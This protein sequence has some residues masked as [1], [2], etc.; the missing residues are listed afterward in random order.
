MKKQFGVSLLLMVGYSHLGGMEQVRQSAHGN[1][2]LVYELHSI[3]VESN[4]SEQVT[5]L[6]L[7]VNMPGGL[8]VAPA[9]V[10]PQQYY[11]RTSM[12]STYGLG[13]YFLGDHPIKKMVGVF[14]CSLGVILII[15]FISPH[16]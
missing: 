3:V 6:G 9:V 14:V 16:V 10:I 7:P 1:G 8:S 11:P 5:E 4:A 15:V 13:S 12:C 2:V